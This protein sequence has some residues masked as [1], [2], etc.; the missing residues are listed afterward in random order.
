MLVPAHD[1]RAL[2][3]ACTALALNRAAARSLADRARQTVAESFSQQ[4]N[5]SR[6]VETYHEVATAP[7]G[8]WREPAYA[9]A[10]VLDLSRSLFVGVAGHACARI[11]GTVNT[12]AARWRVRKLRHDPSPLT[13]ALKSA[14]RILIVCQGNII[15]SPFAARLVQQALRNHGRVSVMSAGLSAVAG[16]PPHPTAVPIATAHSVDL[17]GH[18]ASP[19]GAEAVRASDVIFVMDIAQLVAMNQRF[20]EA[21]ERTFLLTSLAFDAPLEI[22]DPVDG[23][24]SRFQIC[25]EHISTAVRPIVHTLSS[26]PAVQ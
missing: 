19:L 12:A 9:P 10:S 18:A 24:E 6:V 13:W 25:F 14:Q 20:P 5:G 16:R 4:A 22:A 23:D 17:S 8:A 26:S 1:P 21:R 11:A 2:A 15:R 7:D 3:D